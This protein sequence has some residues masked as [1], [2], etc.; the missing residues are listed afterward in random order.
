MKL[1][2]ERMAALEGLHRK[3]VAFGEQLGAIGQI[4]AFAMPVVD[5]AWP[6][7][8]A[9]QS[10]CG[11]AYRVVADLGQALRMRR[12]P[13]AKLSGEHLRAQANAQKGALLAQR[14]LDPVD[15]AADIVVRVVGTHRT[16]KDDGAG[17]VIERLR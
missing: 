6:A 1:E 11:R 13:G 2:A 12:D 8:A 3:I 17:V 14:N 7:R 4:E 16:A 10:R 15:L 5:M 9:R